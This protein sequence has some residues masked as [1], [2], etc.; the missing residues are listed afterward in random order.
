LYLIIYSHSKRFT[1][2]STLNHDKQSRW[3]LN[4]APLSTWRP[5]AIFI[6]FSLNSPFKLVYC[7]TIDVEFNSTSIE[8]KFKAIPPRLA[9]KWLKNIR[10]NLAPLSTWRSNWILHHFLLKFP[11]IACACT[12]I[13]VELNST[14]I[15]CKFKAFLLIITFKWV[16]NKIYPPSPKAVLVFG[17]FLDNHAFKGL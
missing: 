1:N 17:D 15:E 4:L 2:L 13:D 8:Y 9:L 11:L 6:N 3:R 5:I 7:I 10:S 16:I 14:S 12:S